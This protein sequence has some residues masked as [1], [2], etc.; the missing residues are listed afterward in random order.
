MEDEQ[1]GAIIELA[2]CLP[3]LL[4]LLFGLI[5]FSQIILDD[6]MMT[7]ISRQG[8]DLASRGTTLTDTVS[9]LVTQGA[10]LKIGTQG[11]IIVTEVANNT[12]HKPIIV[13]QVQSS[14]GIAAVSA[15]G[16]GTGNAASV[17]SSATTVLN[18]G[19]TL[20]VTEVFY[21]Y[22]PM[23]PIGGFLKHSIASTMYQAAYF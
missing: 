7:G 2:L 20:Y 6:Q 8:S 3:I 10:S 23:T 16:S 5:D 19:Q 12:S 15:V 9:A 18:A 22:K 11:R 1:G 17:P 21:S 13:D 4:T 14:T